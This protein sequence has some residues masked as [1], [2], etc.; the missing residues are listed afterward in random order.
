[1]SNSPIGQDRRCLKCPPCGHIRSAPVIT[2]SLTPGPPE[3]PD[4]GLDIRWTSHSC[5]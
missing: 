4:N 3:A 2:L 5:G 1:F